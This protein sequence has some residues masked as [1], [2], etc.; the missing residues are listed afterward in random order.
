MV[1]SNYFSKETNMKVTAKK[2]KKRERK[3]TV[4]V[5]WRMMSDSSR[6]NSPAS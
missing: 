4:S 1:D 6:C 5:I 3:L 2:F